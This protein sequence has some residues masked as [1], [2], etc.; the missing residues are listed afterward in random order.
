MT[1]A[2]FD[3]H[4]LENQLSQIRGVISAKVVT[5]EGGVIGEIHILAG[6]QRAPKQLVRDIESLSL[7]HFKKRIDYRKISIVQLEGRRISPMSRV[8]LM[9]VERDLDAG[10]QQWK[11]TL[12]Y[13][14]K[15]L[16]GEWEG[17]SSASEAEGAAR[18]TLRALEV[19][20][21]PSL[22]LDLREAILAPIDGGMVVVSAVSVG[23]TSGQETLLG[24][25]FVKENVGE[26]AARSVLGAL[27]R[28]LPFTLE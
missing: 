24:S 10:S 12:E 21:G 9:T 28:R 22:G 18:A 13:E 4:L 8:R 23:T 17:D 19:I 7:L 1:E 25:S 5:G 27:N 2:G 15:E 16:P 26:A 14:R 20:V 6:S 3:P 11:V